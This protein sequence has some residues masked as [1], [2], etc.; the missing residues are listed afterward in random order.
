VTSSPSGAR[1]LID[2]KDTGYK[3]PDTFRPRIL[4]SGEHKVSVAL[5]GYGESEAKDLSVHASPKLI[6]W[7]LIFWPAAIV[8]VFKGFSSVEP[9]RLHFDL[10]AGGQ[11]AAPTAAPASPGSSMAAGMPISRGQIKT[12]G[13]KCAAL[14][15]K[16]MGLSGAIGLVIDDLLLTELQQSGFDPVGRE[17]LNALLDFDKQKSAVDCTDATCIA[18]IGNAL[19][20]PYLVSG[21]VVLMEESLVLTL[22][23]LDVQETRVVARVNKMLDGKD[24]AVPRLIAEGVQELVTRSGL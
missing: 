11:V 14:P 13:L 19:G 4:P 20:V 22:K 23:L 9:N 6:I 8:N 7:S 10:K 24:K 12:R 15:L 2:G 16:T 18:E 21:N 17:D 3:T 1:V 5:D